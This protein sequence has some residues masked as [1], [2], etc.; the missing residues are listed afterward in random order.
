MKTDGS[1]EDIYL[2]W[3]YVIKQVVNGKYASIRFVH[4]V[5]RGDIYVAGGDGCWS[6]GQQ[7]WDEESRGQRFVMYS[8]GYVY[9]VGVLVWC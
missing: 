8:M 6:R 4:M 2:R 7:I 1:N 9:G 3:M 5:L